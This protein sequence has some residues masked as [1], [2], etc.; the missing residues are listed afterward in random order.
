MV[1][2]SWQ[3]VDGRRTAQDAETD[4]QFQQIQMHVIEINLLD[5]RPCLSR[6]LS[7]PEFFSSHFSIRKNIF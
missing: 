3:V 5:T 1:H 4:I 2:D 6:Q 7:A